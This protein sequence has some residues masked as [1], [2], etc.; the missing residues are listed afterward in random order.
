MIAQ[1]NHA[2][3]ALPLS[4]WFGMRNQLELEYQVGHLKAPHLQSS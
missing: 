1:Q 2:V 3:A 4:L